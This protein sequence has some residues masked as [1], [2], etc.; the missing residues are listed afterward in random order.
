MASSP[1]T[2]FKTAVFRPG[3]LQRA[4]LDELEHAFLD[5]VDLHPLLGTSV[6][7]SAFSAS[8]HRTVSLALESGQI[9]CLLHDGSL[10]D[11]IWCPALPVLSQRQGGALVVHTGDHD[12]AVDVGGVVRFE[13][14][15][16][17]FVLS[18]ESRDEDAVR[19]LVCEATLWRGP[20]RRR[21]CASGFFATESLTRT[22]ASGDAPSND[23]HG[24]VRPLRKPASAA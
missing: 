8:D 1:A 10:P 13:R 2:S 21:P 24:T 17:S 20:E 12:V 6:R 23:A 15:G 3:T 22:D 9:V 19:V 7:A 5:R 11:A 16:R 14:E 4:A 18:V